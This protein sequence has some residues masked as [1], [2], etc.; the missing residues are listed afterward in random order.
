VNRVGQS[1][2][3]V[4]LLFG[5]GIAQKGKE[6]KLP[7]PAVQ[8]MMLG[9][10]SIRITYEKSNDLRNGD[11]TTGEEKW[12][13]GPG[14]LSLIE[15]YREHNTRGEIQGLG[16][17]WWDA[18]VNAYH[19]LWCENT[20]PAG[21]SIP[22]GV[23]RWEGDQLALTSEQEDDGKKLKFREVFSEIMPNSFKQTLYRAEGDGELKPF[24]TIRATRKLGRR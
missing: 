6:L 11:V 23:A 22:N 2:L 16:V 3:V 18:S 10:W 9:S 13:S 19:V 1:L 12:Y 15:E 14:G 20:D 21:C 5:F 24:L 4:L 7:G 17:L 8:K